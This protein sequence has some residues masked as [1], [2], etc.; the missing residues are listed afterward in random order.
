M[1]RASLRF[2]S[3]FSTQSTIVSNDKQLE[4]CRWGQAAAHERQFGV[5][6]EKPLE[7]GIKRRL[8]NRVTFPPEFTYG[9][10]P[11]F[12]FAA[13]T[14]TLSASGRHHNL[15]APDEAFPLSCSIRCGI[16][17]VRY[18][19]CGFNLCLKRPCRRRSRATTNKRPAIADKGHA[20]L[21]AGIAQDSPGHEI[22]TR[23]LAAPANI[24]APEH[25]VLSQVLWLLELRT[26]AILGNLS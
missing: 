9:G 16:A 18:R 20:D 25:L 21:N 19:L 14:A 23:L 2:T 5:R 15:I 13:V 11:I 17:A 24:E 26:G 3:T 1:R 4:S 8:N 7:V 22:L 6:N 12:N 10:M